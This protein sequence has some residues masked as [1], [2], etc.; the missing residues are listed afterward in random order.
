MFILS[1]PPPKKKDP[2]TIQGF[3][4]NP[5]EGEF[6]AIFFDAE[7]LIGMFINYFL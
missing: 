2:L 7:A 6:H 1:P 3:R 5:I 4:S